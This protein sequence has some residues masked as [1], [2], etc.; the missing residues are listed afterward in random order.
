ML[1]TKE[2]SP[3]HVFPPTSLQSF[4]VFIIGGYEYLFCLCMEHWVWFSVCLRKW[5][6]IFSFPFALLS[7]P[8]FAVFPQS[9]LESAVFVVFKL[10]HCD[11][12]SEFEI[13]LMQFLIQWHVLV[14]ANE[15]WES[16]HHL[17]GYCTM[18]QQYNVSLVERFSVWSPHVHRVYQL[19]HRKQLF[20][21]WSS[22]ICGMHIISLNKTAVVVWRMFQIL[23]HCFV[24]LPCTCNHGVRDDILRIPCDCFLLRGMLCWLNCHRSSCNRGKVA[25]SRFCNSFTMCVKFRVT[26]R[27][28][29]LVFSF[30][31][32]HVFYVGI[33][34]VAKKTHFANWLFCLK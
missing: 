13:C 1:K 17:I 10:D 19:C 6:M 25:L 12:V 27:S 30:M 23:K 34:A 15:F 16:W 5:R 22:S 7:M 24:E 8:V 18:W 4:Q 33:Q 20:S 14:M 3:L 9:L 32:P 2:C 31:N 11:F 26:C 29:R 28:D 21:Y